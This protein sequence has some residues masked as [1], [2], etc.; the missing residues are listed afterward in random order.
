MAEHLL[1]KWGTV[2]DWGG[3]TEQSQ[4]IMRRY[5]ADGIPMSC[6]ADHPDESRKVI[7]CE[8]IDQLDGQIQDDWSGEAMTKAEAKK[9]IMEYD[10]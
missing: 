10:L 7:L 2:K 8:L 5:F 6:M 3:F 9:Y 1:L 4:K